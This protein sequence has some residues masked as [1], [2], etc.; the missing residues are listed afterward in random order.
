MDCTSSG[1]R[2]TQIG[3]RGSATYFFRE[4]HHELYIHYVM[5]LKKVFSKI[6]FVVLFGMFI[7][8]LVALLRSILFFIYFCP[9]IIDLYEVFL[10]LN[11]DRDKIAHITVVYLNILLI[12]N[13][14]LFVFSY[15]FL[16]FFIE[17]E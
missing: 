3:T 7:S 15:A 17:N 14:I 9:Q 11:I 6:N 1:G 16:L 10:F 5:T 2:I 8:C 12:I 13:L 4:T